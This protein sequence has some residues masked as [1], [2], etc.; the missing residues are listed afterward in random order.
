MT[1]PQ[2]A[3]YGDSYGYPSSGPAPQQSDNK[4]MGKGKVVLIFILGVVGT[5]VALGIIGTIWGEEDSSDNA[6]SS[7][8]SV[9]TVTE[10]APSETSDSPTPTSPEENATESTGQVAEVQNSDSEEVEEPAGDSNA[11]D[12]NATREQRNALRS[13][14]N[15]LNLMAFSDP[16]LRKQLDYEGFP[17]DAIEYAMQNITVDWNAQAVKM[18]Q[19]YDQ[20][21]LAMSNDGLY[22]QL[23]YE[24]FTP[25]QAQYGVDN[26]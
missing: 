5:L 16:G 21:G 25:E 8:S 14:N 1:A 10:T 19:Q 4:G 11:A 3:P 22:D 18:A 13:A 6:S 26:M 15:Y 2:P 7:S 12:G 9:V 23:I 24:G 20:S 17:A